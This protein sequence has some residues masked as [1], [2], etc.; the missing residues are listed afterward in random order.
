MEKIVVG[1][2]GSAPSNQ[3]LA[4][5]LAEAARDGDATVV[6]VHGYR[7]PLA[8]DPSAETY[9]YLPA[10]STRHLAEHHR[11][12]HDEQERMARQRA[13]AVV[14][15]ALEAVGGAP[16]GINVKVVVLAR[17][18]AKALVDL[19]GDADLLVVGSRGRGGF[20]GLLLGSVSQQCLHHAR[21]PVLVV[22]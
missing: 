17:P 15:R 5:A 2:D 21:C 9:P 4:W 14:D 19:S 20:A 10:E 12:E 3:A 18:P 1:I 11:A 6:L 13:E 16:P 8:R 22:R 7:P